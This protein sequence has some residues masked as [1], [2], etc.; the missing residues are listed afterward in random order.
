MIVTCKVLFM[1]CESSLIKKDG[2]SFVLMYRDLESLSIFEISKWL[3]VSSFLCGVDN[4]PQN[5]S[6][7]EQDK[8]ITLS[9]FS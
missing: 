2:Q 9:F 4:C 8:H 1:K 5:I 7:L 6:S 3:L